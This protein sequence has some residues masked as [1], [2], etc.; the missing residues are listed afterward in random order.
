VLRIGLSRRADRFPI[1]TDDGWILSTRR[2]PMRGC[3]IRSTVTHKVRDFLREQGAALD[4]TID[5]CENGVAN[6][7][8]PGTLPQ[9]YCTPL[10]KGAVLPARS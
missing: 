10:Y 6:G 8:L 3:A 1:A 2:C 7:E 5:C 4:E 9:G